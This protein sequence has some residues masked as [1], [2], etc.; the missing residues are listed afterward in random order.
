MARLDAVIIGAQKAG[1]SSLAR[2][3]TMLAPVTTHRSGEFPFF[4]DGYWWNRG[5]DDAV[6]HFFGRRPPTSFVLAKSAGILFH[7]SG[8]ER[9]ATVQPDSKIIAVLRDPVDRAR[10][11]FWFNRRAGVEVATT[12]EAALKLETERLQSDYER[13]HPCAYVG[14]GLYGEQLDR[15]LSIYPTE[16][17]YVTDF[18]SLMSHP[19]RVL[20]E[21]FDFIDL[22][23]SRELDDFQLPRENPSGVARSSALA[24]LLS[25]PPRP[26][27]AAF[28]QLPV[29]K[30]ELV[31]RFAA[32]N[33]R[34]L[35]S[36]QLSATTRQRLHETFETS[37]SHTHK[38]LGWE[39][40]RW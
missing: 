12:L 24:K 19:S 38:L 31:Q 2:A 35:P 3:V 10:S 30:H 20:R 13:W 39:D 7:R 21:I 29:A 5:Y 16:Q 25:S 9:L 27:R 36:P 14:R 40:A 1:T 15:L 6:D 23:P 18:A 4:V 8:L 34:T 32:L 17:I 33:Q 22:E 11:A 26:L 28:R 37:S